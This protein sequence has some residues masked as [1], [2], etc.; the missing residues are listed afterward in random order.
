MVEHLYVKFGA[1]RSSLRRF[2]RYRVEN[3]RIDKHIS[4]TENLTHTTSVGVGNKAL[5]LL[6]PEELS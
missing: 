3:R 6:S 2:L 4:A 1:V 5:S